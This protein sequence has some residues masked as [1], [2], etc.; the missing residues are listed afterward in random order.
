M[1]ALNTILTVPGESQEHVAL[2]YFLLNK[3]VEKFKKFYVRVLAKPTQ[4]GLQD[5]AKAAYG[6]SLE[7]LEKEWHEH[8]KTPSAGWK[9]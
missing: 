9:G 6:K 1:P 4:A 2:L 7:A 8:L 5:A 3:D